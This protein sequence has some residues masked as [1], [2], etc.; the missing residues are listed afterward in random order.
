MKQLTQK[1]KNGQMQVIEVPPPL[2]RSGM[3]MVRNHYSLISAGTEGSTVQ[4][5]R[6]SLIGKVK[7]RPQQVKQV[8]ELLKQKGPVQT[9]RSV[10]KRLDAYSPLGYSSAG[11]VI[12]VAQDVRGFSNGDLVACGG[13]GYANHAEIG[14]VPANLCVKLP[15]DADLKKAAYNTLGA[16]ALQGIRQADLEIGECCAVIGLGLIGQLTCLILRAG[17]IKVL[18]IDINQKTVDI[19]REHCADLAFVRDEFGLTKEIDEFTNGIGVDAVIIT[20][21][22]DTVDPV[23][24]AGKISR[25]RGRVVIVGDVPTGFDRESYYRKELELR[26]SCSYGPGRY[27]S[28]YEEKGID[29]PV[30]Y[31]RWTENRNMKAFQELVHSG[32]IAMDYLTT[33]IYDLEQAPHAYNLIL[34]K[35]EPYLGILIEYRGEKPVLQKKI[36]IS[37][38]PS[39]LSPHPSINIAFIGA[40]NYAMSYLLPNVPKDED[41]V[42]QGVMTTSGTSSRKIA[43]KYKFEFCTS[44]ESDIFGNDNI[45]TIFIATRNNTH[46]EY[47]IKGLKA[48]KNVFV[49]KPLCTTIQE[50]RKIGRWY[51]QTLKSERSRTLMVGFN[52]RF[53][54]LTEIVRERIGDGPMAMIYRIN[55][56]LIPSDS[57]IQDKD[58]GGGRIIGEICHFVDFITFVNGSLPEHVF[59]TAMHDPKDINDTVNVSLK[60]KNGSIG[61][62]SYISNG[63]KALFKEYIEV[64]REGITAIIK[65]FRELEI[66]G[67]GKR[68]KKKLFSQDKGQKKMVKTFIESVKN[69]KPAPISFEEIYAVT[70]TTFRI[71]ESI[72]R[73]KAIDIF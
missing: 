40:G 8:F 45:N 61:T 43:E 36:Q 68:F 53:S 11:E 7:E 16:I 19:A 46:T 44:D 37:P 14:A 18:G 21:A 23:N 27:D 3:V 30:G 13:A 73:R 42:L 63:S 70:L 72:R 38:H 65:D 60:F 50:L 9:Y 31:V 6:K 32:K 49:E 17:G 56:G 41:V 66:Y 64:Y 4:A 28:N 58:I 48:D 22:A 62:I 10:M 59:A 1:L 15:E 25:K 54:P 71:V 33:H 12:K 52:R 35:Y 2:L 20:A 69:G 67:N 29:Y 55:A 34:K 24:F 26:M 51:E 39:V 47:V 5:A 57:W